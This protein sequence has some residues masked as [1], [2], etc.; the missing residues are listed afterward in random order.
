MTHTETY[1]TLAA[2]A[3]LAY[4]ATE[5]MAWADRYLAEKERQQREL[6]ERIVAR[7]MGAE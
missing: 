3:L 6:A 2:I 1:I 7:C 5:A 4:A